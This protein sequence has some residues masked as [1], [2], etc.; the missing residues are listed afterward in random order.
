M[1]KK[2]REGGGE[3]AEVLAIAKGRERRRLVKEKGK[4]TL[5]NRCLPRKGGGGKDHGG[6]GEKKE[7]PL[8]FLLV[9]SE[10]GRGGETWLPPK[11]GGKGIFP[12]HVAGKEEG[13]GRKFHFWSSFF[14]KEKKGKKPFFP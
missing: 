4:S 8:K 10:G 3:R 1:K 6:W 7:E 11:K 9:V 5:R 12:C 2:E 14:G 13:E